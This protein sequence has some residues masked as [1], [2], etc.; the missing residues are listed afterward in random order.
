MTKL[1]VSSRPTVAELRALLSSHSFRGFPVVN[2]DHFVGYIKRKSLEE[3]LQC[4]SERHSEEG[5]VGLDDALPFTDCTVMRMV[6][7]A[8]LTQVHKVFKQLGCKC[9]FLV[10][11]RGRGTPDILQ[12][13]LT[14]KNF[15]RFLKSGRVGHMANHPSTVLPGFPLLGNMTATG[16]L[17]RMLRSPRPARF[18]GTAEEDES[19]ST[20]GSQPGTVPVSPES[21]GFLSPSR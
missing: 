9:I 4:V 2:G 18:A 20:F 13:M 8:P 16:F 5:C 7:D 11:S 6:P 14:K 15:L 10:G 1:D 12:G 17:G 3:L 21:N 19:L